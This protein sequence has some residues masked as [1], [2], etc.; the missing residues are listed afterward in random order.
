M[1]TLWLRPLNKFGSGAWVWVV[2]R[3]KNKALLVRW[4]WRFWEER[5]AFGEESLILSMVRTSGV[6]GI[7]LDQGSVGRVY[8]VVLPQLGIYPTS[9]VEVLFKGVGFVMG[10]GMGAGPLYVL[11]PRIF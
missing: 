6:G 1:Q 2:W 9:V 3:K 10:D 8:G 11:F 5:D 4:W 7:T